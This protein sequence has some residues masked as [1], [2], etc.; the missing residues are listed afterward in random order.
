M[1]ISVVTGATAITSM[2]KTLAGMPL[3]AVREPESQELVSLLS[4]PPAIF[5]ASAFP[6][7]ALPCVLSVSPYAI[8]PVS[9]GSLPNSSRHGSTQSSIPNA[10][11][12]RHV[13]RH[14]LVSIMPE[15]IGLSSAPVTPDPMKAIPIRVPCFTLNQLFMTT[16][17]MMLIVLIH[18]PAIIAEIYHCQMAL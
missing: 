18:I 11:M 9:F 17:T 3:P 14:P 6:S 13:L 2:K 4:F 15:N 1:L 5:A 8:S 7:D 16:G 10:P 12:I